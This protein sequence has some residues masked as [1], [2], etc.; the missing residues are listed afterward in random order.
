MRKNLQMMM[1]LFAI[2]S[3]FLIS[4]S[5]MGSYD[6]NQIDSYH[7]SSGL[8]YHSPIVIS[9]DVEFDNFSF[10]G[11][12]TIDS[13]YLIQNYEIIATGLG[14]AGIYISGTSRFFEI[15]NCYIKSSDDAAIFINSVASGTV[16]IAD[17]YLRSDNKFA[18]GIWNGCH[19]STVINNTMFAEWD[20]LDMFNCDNSK[21]IG[22]QMSNSDSG[23]WIEESDNCLI[24][25]NTCKDNEYSGIFVCFSDSCIIINNTVKNNGYEGI[26]LDTVSNSLIENNFCENNGWYNIFS[27][28]SDYLEI[29]NNTCIGSDSGI[30]LD[31][32]YHKIID[33]LCFRNRYFGI[34][35]EYINNSTIY[36][37]ALLE[38]WRYGVSINSSSSENNTINFN[39][40]IYN[41]QGNV[42]AYDE[43]IGNIWFDGSKKQGN[44]WSDLKFD[45]YSIDGPAGSVDLYP[46]PL[47]DSDNDGL[48]DYLEEFI[49]LTD[50]YD[51]DTDDDGYLDGEE[52]EAG[53]DPHN[54]LDYPGKEN[55]TNTTDDDTNKDENEGQTFTISSSY[56]YLAALFMVSLTLIFRKKRKELKL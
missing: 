49:Y 18:L 53:T 39:R 13:P 35:L 28:C 2:V 43:G 20:C 14:V 29:Y 27:L 23:T 17:N 37:N 15:R 41:N 55:N 32:S 1:I 42:Q 56:T 21:I 46:L 6:K 8:I 45:S 4:P 47:Q 40:F 9:S 25:N 16:F 12:G 33:N 26:P 3:S 52:I 48:D 54:P 5:L 34:N 10:P 22:N 31:G 50:V 11:N 24:A 51:N 36:R 19:Y 44:Y 38:N 7:L 30:I